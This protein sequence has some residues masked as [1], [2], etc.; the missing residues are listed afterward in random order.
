LLWTLCLRGLNFMK[1]AS[2]LT[3]FILILDTVN[4]HTNTCRGA[5][6]IQHAK[7]M[8]GIILPSVACKKLI[9]PHYLIHG[10]I[11]ETKRV[12]G[13]EMCVLYLLYNIYLEYI[14]IPTKVQRNI[15]N[16]LRSSCKVPVILAKFSLHL[17]FLDRFWKKIFKHEISWRSV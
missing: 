10:T 8:C 4:R 12:T 17:N 6:L 15:L 13:H 11:F 2:Y 3:F 5:L 14:L 9:F 1:T 16:V 7:R